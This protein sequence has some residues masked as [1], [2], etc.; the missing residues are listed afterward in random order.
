MKI[1]IT[2]IITSKPSALYGRDLDTSDHY[3]F[4]CEDIDI[5]RFKHHEVVSVELK[6]TLD[7]TRS[8]KVSRIEPT[9]LFS[10]DVRITE[11]PLLIKGTDAPNKIYELKGLAY[12]PG[13][14]DHGRDISVLITKLALVEMSV[15][16]DDMIASFS[17][18]RRTSSER[19]ERDRF[20][21]FDDGDVIT[22]DGCHLNDDSAK[23]TFSLSVSG[24]CRGMPFDC[25]ARI[26]EIRK[27]RGGD[28][29][30]YGA[31]LARNLADVECLDGPYKGRNLTMVWSRAS[32]L[33]KPGTQISLREVQKCP[34]YTFAA[35]AVPL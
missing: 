23:G 20:V 1:I 13:H 2:G 34:G 31:N 30:E 21:S 10:F 17:E 3:C 28:Y 4:D 7:P 32:E 5:G 27:D 8:N 12:H 9:N 22:F 24:S 33:L 35:T 25:N 26:L 15:P 29:S 19:N 11:F 14:I 18:A 6:S 16:A